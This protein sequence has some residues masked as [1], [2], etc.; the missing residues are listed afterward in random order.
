MNRGITSLLL[1]LLVVER[2]V[3]I[4]IPEITGPTAAPIYFRNTASP[5][6]VP[7][8]FFGTERMIRFKA[9]VFMKRYP[10]EMT[11]RCTGI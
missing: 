3:H 6:D 11:K 8:I 7:I 10:V 2:C 9:A 1:L 5:S 4:Y